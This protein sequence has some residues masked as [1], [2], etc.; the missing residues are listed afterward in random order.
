MHPVMKAIL[1]IAVY[2]AL[3]FALGVVMALPMP[4]EGGGPNGADEDF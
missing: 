3:V 1:C 4:R 2:L